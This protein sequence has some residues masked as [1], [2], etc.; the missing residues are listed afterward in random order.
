MEEAA[1]GSCL[2][3]FFPF[4]C[5]EQAPL[6]LPLFVPLHSISFFL[7]FSSSLCERTLACTFLFTVF[8]DSSRVGHPVRVLP[9]GNLRWYAYPLAWTYPFLC[10]S[11]FFG[12]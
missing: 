3:R 1:L 4:L 8:S 10:S 12:P 11:L 5:P 6:A 7:F 9:G 2:L